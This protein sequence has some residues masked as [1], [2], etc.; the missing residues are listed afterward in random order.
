MFNIEIPENCI[1]DFENFK[2][3]FGLSKKDYVRFSCLFFMSQNPVTKYAHIK[4]MME[5]DLSKVLQSQIPS[6]SKK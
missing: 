3:H 5:S 6:R 4:I 1:K 2:K